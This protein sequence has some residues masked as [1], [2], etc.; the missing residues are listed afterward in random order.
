MKPLQA[1]AMGFVFVVLEAKWPALNGY[2]AYFDPCGWLL[3]LYGVRGLPDDL[4]LRGSVRTLGLLALAASVPLSVPQVVDWLGDT[5]RALAW[6][7]YLPQ[8]GF[9]ALL[10]H[11]LS[12]SAA[13]AEERRPAMWLRV[14]VTATLV[15][16]IAPILVFGAGLT[17]LAD[18]AELVRF[19]VYVMAVWLLFSYSGRPWAGAPPVD[20][21]IGRPKRG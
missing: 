4:R 20:E 11:A 9:V 12:L 6:A 13:E 7:A 16:M 8:F 18:P 19:L 17:G 10:F 3:I 1:I 5:E 15:V 2:D 21:S 14:V